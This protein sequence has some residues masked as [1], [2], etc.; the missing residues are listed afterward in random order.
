MI[1]LAKSQVR[2]GVGPFA[3]G[4]GVGGVITQDPLD[5]VDGSPVTANPY[6]YASNDPIN[7]VDPLGLRDNDWDL[8]SDYMGPP[9]L[10]GGGGRFGARHV[11][12]PDCPKFLKPYLF[13]STPGSPRLHTSAGSGFAGC[14]P[15]AALRGL[16]D[17]S[18]SIR[19]WAGVAG[20]SVHVL[21][22]TLLHEGQYILQGGVGGFL[23][24][25]EHQTKSF[26]SVIGAPSSGIGQLQAQAAR[27]AYL[28]LTGRDLV[29]SDIGILTKLT[30][31]D[32]F[33][34]SMAAGYL[35][36]IKE[37]DAEAGG[38]ASDRALFM[39]YAAGS[40]TRTKFREG[41]YSVDALESAG[42]LPDVV[43]VMREREDDWWDVDAAT[44]A[45]GL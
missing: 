15:G 21:A 17:L 22:S 33:S 36:H 44:R 31:D 27:T 41:G 18:P 14:E 7:R 40:T 26:G 28:A 19:Q 1:E 45:V 35:R 20:V 25:V 43:A 30:W 12:M 32:E 6:H 34:I 39:M 42:I 23:E 8:R 29:G 16:V 3:E 13:E 24:R 4:A 5:G 11:E 2:S 10:A 9:V 38:R 37:E